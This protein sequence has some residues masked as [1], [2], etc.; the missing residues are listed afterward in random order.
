MPKAL[1]LLRGVEEARRL[2]MDVHRRGD[3]LALVPTMGYLH[4]GHLALMREAIGAADRVVATIFVN[5]MQFGPNEDLSRYPR[6]LSGDLAKCEAAGVEAVFAP[7][8]AEIY[9][10]GFQTFVEVTEVSRGLC[11]ERR[12]GHFRGVATVVAKLL[13]LFRPHVAVFG[14]KDYQQLH[15][16]RR[17]NLDLNLGSEIVSVPTVREQDGLAMSSRNACLSPSERARALSLSSGLRLAQELASSGVH[18]VRDLLKAMR[19][20]LE[21]A[22]V[23]EDYIAIV[24][25]QTL[26][27]LEELPSSRPARALVAAF[28][29]RTRLIDNAAVD[30]RSAD[31][32]G[33]TQR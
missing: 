1:K 5:P 19:Q 11:G 6:D 4:D 10:P 22:Q 2:S 18:Q 13:S 33:Q 24:D 32:R 14:E 16:I 3:R 20:E 26:A 12:P 27:P 17:L 21:R 8:A 31:G 30:A 28:V 25:E 15:V 29:G 7:D 23:R 9:P